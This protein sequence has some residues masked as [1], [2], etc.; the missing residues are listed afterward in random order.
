MATTPLGLG[1]I[2]R[3][4]S[5][6]FEKLPELIDKVIANAKDLAESARKTATKIAELVGEDG[7]DTRV[8]P[9]A[10]TWATH[11]VSVN[12]DSEKV[13]GRDGLRRH[14]RS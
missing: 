7:M 12:L 9:D 4:D 2:V 3:L 6:A 14:R 11:P 5:L 1:A 8:A 10:S 13:V